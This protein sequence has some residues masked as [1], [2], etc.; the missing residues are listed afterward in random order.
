MA[1]II[2]NADT[3]A[4]TLSVTLDGKEIA[5]VI[6]VSIDY[7]RPYDAREDDEE[8]EVRVSITSGKD[9]GDG[10]MTSTF[11]SCSKETQSAIASDLL[12]ALKLRTSKPL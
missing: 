1:K 6:Y 9:E 12:N 10:V 8:K 4:D 11:I 2:I 7:C 5:D 3:E